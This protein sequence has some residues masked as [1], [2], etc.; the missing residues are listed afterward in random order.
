MA[1]LL[2]GVITVFAA[3]AN[4]SPTATDWQDHG[5][6]YAQTDAGPVVGFIETVPNAVYDLNVY[7]GIPFAAP[8]ERWT[9]PEPPSPWEKPYDASSIGPACI[10]QFNYPEARRSLI[11]K[12]F[13]TPAAPESE[14]C[15]YLNVYAPKTKEPKPVMV[16]IYGGGNLYG[17]NFNPL[18]DGENL[19]AN[20]GVVTVILNYR[21]NVFGFPGADELPLTGRNLG[22]DFAASNLSEPNS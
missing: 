11:L 9:V 16:W 1:L 15:L 18:Y 13:N 8:P 10:Q 12:W 6:P 2:A 3:L 14:D 19:A 17:S 7:L 21:T 5:R 20:E 22:Y 4:A